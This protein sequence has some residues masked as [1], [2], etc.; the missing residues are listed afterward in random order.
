[1]VSPDT[2]APDSIAADSGA[3]DS[4]SAETAFAIFFNEGPGYLFVTNLG[5]GNFGDA[6][7]VRS[8]AHPYD[9][10]VRKRVTWQE[11]YSSNKDFHDEVRNQRRFRYIPE[12]IDWTSYG[13][14][15]YAM[16]MQYCNGGTLKDL[17][18]GSRGGGPQPIAEIF[19][20]KMFMQLLETLD[21]LHSQSKPPVAHCDIYLQNI[22]LHWPNC[23]SIEGSKPRHHLPE[24]FLGD[25]GVAESGENVAACAFDMRRLSTVLIKTCLGSTHLPG[26]LAEWKKRMPRCYSVQLKTALA[27]L[28]RP[29]EGELESQPLWPVKPTSVLRQRIMPIALRKMAEL[30]VAEDKVDYRSKKPFYTTKVQLEKTRE[31]FLSHQLRE[32]SFHARV[33]LKTSEIIEIV[34]D[35]EKETPVAQGKGLLP[36]NLRSLKLGL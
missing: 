1:M 19:I 12:L 18:Y 9:L 29:Y 20:W 36:E 26:D 31:A 7:L 22:F 6:M 34:P 13:Q 28:P 2:V 3:A 4:V 24:V 15:S 23:C 16:T 25:F 14:R 17:I 10:Y 5:R 27:I 32:P 33:D 30:E 35:C 8:C 21:F 11:N